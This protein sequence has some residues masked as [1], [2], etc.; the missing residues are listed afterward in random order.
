MSYR[1]D[2]GNLYK[3]HVL[4]ENVTGGGAAPLPSAPVVQ[5]QVASA[6]PVQ[7]PY[8]PVS[9]ASQQ[10]QQPVKSETVNF[11]F[12]FDARRAAFFAHLVYNAVHRVAKSFELVNYFIEELTRIHRREKRNHQLKQ[13]AK[14]R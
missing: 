9:A 10:E 2:L 13:M 6:P 11:D 5:Q 1:H 4:H 8:F 14:L 12:I 3:A 7:K